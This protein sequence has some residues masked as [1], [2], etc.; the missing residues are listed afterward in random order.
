MPLPLLKVRAF[1]T[2]MRPHQYSKNLFIFA[3]AFFG[4]GQYDLGAVALD[5]LVAFCGFCLI[6]SGI[7]AI[8]DCLDAKLDALHPSKASRPVASGA[9]SPLLAY[10]FGIALILL[11][12]GA[13][14]I[15][16]K[17][18]EASALLSLYAPII[19][20]IVLNLAYC[21]Y[22]KHIAIVDVFC[23][24]SGFVLRLWV[25][26]LVIAIGLS[27]W[28]VITTFL[29]AVFLALAKRR[30]DI[31]LLESG[32]KVRKNIDGYNRAFLD[33]AMG[34]SASL[35]MVAYIFYSID[36]SVNERLH[37]HN[38]YLTAVFVLLGI[39]RYMQITFVLQKSSSPSKILLHDRFLQLVILAWLAS[40]III[41]FW[42]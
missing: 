16:S 40:F 39:F 31:L 4:F 6:A 42:R 12:G 5:L 35:V 18:L 34:I 25:G 36:E 1:I 11:G 21:L 13:Y 22:L 38:L 3:P 2:L 15:M 19:I 8:N 20:Y 17:D 9:I 27:H 7:Y 30:D 24:A 29:L 26:A 37:T 10:I 32:T 14:M 23:I 28:I 33:I 41:G